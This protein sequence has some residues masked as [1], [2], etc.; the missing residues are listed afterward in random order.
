M[1]QPQRESRDEAEEVGASRSGGL[2]AVGDTGG[3]VVMSGPDQQAQAAQ[4]SPVSTA[5]VQR[6]ALSATVSEDGTL[7]Y[8]AWS[9]GLPYSVITAGPRG[10]HEAPRGRASGS[11]GTGALPRQRQPGGSPVW[12]NACLPHPVARNDPG[13]TWLSSTRTCRSRIH[14]LHPAEPNFVHVWARHNHR[15]AEAPGRRRTDPDRR[16]NSWP[17][18]VRTD[19]YTSDD[20]FSA[21]RG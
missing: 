18:G 12:R 3:V 14:D 15:R 13:R 11:S 6:E 19:R 21:A 5:T 10:I 1:W 8:G 4:R 2:I 7:T 16:A 20:P 9:D 17:G